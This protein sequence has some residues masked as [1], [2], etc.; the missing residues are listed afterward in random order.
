MTFAAVASALTAGAAGN[1][2]VIL[3]AALTAIAAL[4]VGVYTARSARA[5]GRETAQLAGWQKMAE[6]HD[7]EITRLREDR[8]EDERRYRR[9][10]S[11]L[12]EQIARLTARTEENERNGRALTAWARRV[13]VIMREAELTFP[14]PP[15]LISDTDPG[16]S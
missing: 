15:I 9:E 4:A 8:D 2:A 12:R 14:P 13:V 11:D 16:R 5:A 1:L 6:A 7:K 10:I 3:P